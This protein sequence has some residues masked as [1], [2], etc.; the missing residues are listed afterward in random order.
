[1]RR[2]LLAAALSSVAVVAA[3]QEAD[4]AAMRQ[5]HSMLETNVERLLS[6]H[7]IEAD[8]GALTL[9]QLAAITGVAEQSGSMSEADLRSQLESIIRRQ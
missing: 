7:N 9:V 3:A 1:M 6:H 8:V 5:A 4:M 2:L